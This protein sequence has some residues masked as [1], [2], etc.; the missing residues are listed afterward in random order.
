MLVAAP[1]WGARGEDDGGSTGLKPEEVGLK[2]EEVSMSPGRWLGSHA[3]DA[4]TEGDGDAQDLP[5]EDTTIIINPFFSSRWGS[6]N[7]F[8]GSWRTTFLL[9]LSSSGSGS[10]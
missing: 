5:R 7:H 3:V 6:A 4:D 1:K 2:L 9:S 10:S 8:G